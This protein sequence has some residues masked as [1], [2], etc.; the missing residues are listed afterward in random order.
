VASIEFV[1]MLI[2]WVII[3][4]GTDFWVCLCWVDALFLVFCFLF[5]F[6]DDCGLPDLLACMGGVFTGNAQWCW[7]LGRSDKWGDG[8]QERMVCGIHRRC[9]QRREGG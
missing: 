2:S 8:A 3:D 1:L 5:G 9:G 6:S 4:I 7:G